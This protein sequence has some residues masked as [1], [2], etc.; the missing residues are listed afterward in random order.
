MQ[1][2]L[3]LGLQL[4]ELVFARMHDLVNADLAL[5]QFVAEFADFCREK[6]RLYRIWAAS[7]LP[8]SIRLAMATSPSF[9]RSGT[10]PISLRYSRTGSSVLPTPTSTSSSSPLPLRPSSRTGFSVSTPS[11]RS[12]S[13]AGA[14]FPVMPGIGHI[15]VDFA[16]SEQG[17]NAVELF[18]GHVFV[19]DLVV[20]CPHR[21]HSCRSLAGARF[22]RISCFV[23][24]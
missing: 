11:S 13:S 9:D 7:R 3:V 1:L 22:F 23:P 6:G 12:S 15:D 20:R 18:S 16:V 14:H 21:G 4:L 19:R 2:F 5:A 24:L 10:V 8:S 17:D